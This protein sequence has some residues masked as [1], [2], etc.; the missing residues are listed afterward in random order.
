[1][2][3]GSYH[4]F[5]FLQEQIKDI[6]IILQ[7]FLNVV[8]LFLR[9]HILSILHVLEKHRR[10]C[11]VSGVD[12]KAQLLYRIIFECREGFAA[13]KHPDPLVRRPFQRLTKK[14][15]MFIPAVPIISS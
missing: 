7:A 5:L 10:F 15:C 2:E 3:L 14:V 6:I 8:I 11:Q 1:M 9:S 13:R 4:K 12:R